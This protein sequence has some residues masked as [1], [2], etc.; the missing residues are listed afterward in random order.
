MRGGEEGE[1]EGRGGAD[2]VAELI[3]AALLST[4]ITND[5]HLHIYSHR[6]ITTSTSRGHVLRLSSCATQVVLRDHAEALDPL[7]TTSFTCLLSMG[8]RKHVHFCS[9][10][11]CLGSATCSGRW[12]SSHFLSVFF[13]EMNSKN[14]SVWYLCM[15]AYVCACTCV[16]VCAWCVCVFA[17][18][19]VR[20]RA[21][22]C[23]CALRQVSMKQG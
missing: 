10:L 13:S 7:D 21:F 9:Q 8:S 18:L 12:V 11:T 22:V 6:T 23:A 15:H 5:E 19:R 16:R 20:V 14:I 3:V 17:R 1:G 2:L 4:T